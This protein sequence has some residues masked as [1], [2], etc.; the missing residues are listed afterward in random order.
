[1]N[2]AFFTKNIHFR[3]GTE[4][5]VTTIA[6]SLSKLRSNDKFFVI[7]KEHVASPAFPLS[8]KIEVLALST[9]QENLFCKS[10]LFCMFRMVKLLKEQ[11]INLVIINESGRAAYIIAA[12]KMARV[13]CIIW[14]PAYVLSKED[15]RGKKSLIRK[16]SIWATSKFSDGIVTTTHAEAKIWR[17]MKSPKIQLKCIHNTIEEAK[18]V[19]FDPHSHNVVAVGRLVR[20]KGFD[21][22]LQVWKQICNSFQIG[23]WKLYIVGDDDKE[24]TFSSDIKDKA[25]QLTN[26][27]FLP[28]TPDIAF[29]YAKTGIFVCTSRYECHPLPLI[30]AQSCG[31]PAVAFDCM[32]GPSETIVNDQTGYLLPLGDIK[33]FARAL[34]KLMM[35]Q[36]LRKQFSSQSIENVKKFSKGKIV[37]QWDD[38]INSVMD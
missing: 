27:T 29:I 36:N 28:S 38:F 17:V 31:I 15:R 33:S 8:Q 18:I 26:V 37:T 35:S 22:L 23:N 16:I 12:C 32:S 13:K 7:E 1:M 2:I 25:S 4:Q 20:Q 3:A 10:Y 11:E 24:F 6:N 34:Y 19:S 5:I 9:Q 14:D 30:E 21:L